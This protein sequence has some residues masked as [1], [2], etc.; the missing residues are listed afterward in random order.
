MGAM[1]QTLTANKPYTDLRKWKLYPESFY[2]LIVS[3]SGGTLPT[4]GGMN[5]GNAR[6]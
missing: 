5:E 3:F 2:A 1:N 6:E 4:Q